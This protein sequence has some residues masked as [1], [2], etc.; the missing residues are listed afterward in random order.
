MKKLTLLVGAALL[1]SAAHA[2]VRTSAPTTN[3]TAPTTRT[4]PTTAMTAAGTPQAIARPDRATASTIDNDSYVQQVGDGQQAVVSQTGTGRN[5]ADILQSPSAVTAAG[6]TNDRNFAS[7]TQVSTGM[8]TSADQNIANIR[9]HGATSAAL[10]SQNGTRN[11]GDIQQG[12]Y[13]PAYHSESNY[14]SQTQTGNDNSANIYQ[15][16]NS[17]AAGTGAGQNSAVQT[18]TANGNRAYAL[19]E[20]TN[21]TLVQTQS[22]AS[23]NA[24]TRQYGTDSYA[25]Q[26]QSGVGNRASILQGDDLGASGSSNQAIQMQSS[27]NNDARIVQKTS[28]SY[29]RQ[30]QSVGSGNFADTYQGGA[31]G[32]N[33]SYNMTTQTGSNNTV[34]VTQGAAR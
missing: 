19:Q 13:G 11:V 7:Q 2:Q 28:D 30:E 3:P 6:V 16:T 10:Q 14:A 22:A 23:N 1:V 26:E 15:N 24:D 29:A 17:S 5:T 25:K 31:I 34:Y 4:A 21:N 27:G 9:Q 33:A 8:K 18:Q 32:T 12:N 20:K